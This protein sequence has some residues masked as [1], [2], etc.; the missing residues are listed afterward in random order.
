MKHDVVRTHGGDR[1]GSLS[2]DVNTSMCCPYKSTEGPQYIYCN[3]DFFF[4]VKA[5]DCITRTRWVGSGAPKARPRSTRSC[6]VRFKWEALSQEV[7][8]EMFKAFVEWSA[9]VSRHMPILISERGLLFSL[10]SAF[11]IEQSEAQWPKRY[12]LQIQLGELYPL[13]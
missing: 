3:F 10:H 4:K 8:R 13:L 2:Y 7:L 12:L 1:R 11:R 6:S 5:I 9:K